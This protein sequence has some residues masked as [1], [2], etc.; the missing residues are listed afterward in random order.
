MIKSKTK[1]YFDSLLLIF[2]LHTSAVAIGLFLLPPQYLGFFG[3]EGYQGRFFQSQAGIFH[4]VWVWHIYLPCISG[5]K[6]LL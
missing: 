1:F 6:R 2:V 4:L 3:L 5:K